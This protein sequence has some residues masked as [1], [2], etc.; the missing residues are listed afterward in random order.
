[1]HRAAHWPDLARRARGL[2]VSFA[3]AALAS[4]M[5]LWL[6]HDRL[7]S[8]TDALSLPQAPA[9]SDNVDVATRLYVEETRGHVASSAR[10]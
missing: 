6:N 9:S 4:S 2:L 10:H 1:V 7:L 3:E 5:S 8:R